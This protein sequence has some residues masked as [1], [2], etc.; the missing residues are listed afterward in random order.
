MFENIGFD[1]AKRGVWAVFEPV[2]ER[3]QD[4][5]FEIW[6]WVSRNHFGTLVISDRIVADT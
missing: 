1:I 2:S 3:G 6:T 5:V 4:A